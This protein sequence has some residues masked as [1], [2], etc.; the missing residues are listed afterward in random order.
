M[1]LIILLFNSDYL[2]DKDG[3]KVENEDG[4]MKLK[5]K[6]FGRMNLIFKL[7]ISKLGFM[8]FFMNMWKKKIW[9]I[10]KVISE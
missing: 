5:M 7:S 9:A 3:K 8:E 10:F 4:K 2:P 6:R 1:Y